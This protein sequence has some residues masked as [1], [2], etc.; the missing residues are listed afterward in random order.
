MIQFIDNTETT[1][2]LPGP[3]L[4]DPAELEQIELETV[5][6]AVP[7]ATVV[8][9]ETDEEADPE[10][11]PQADD[12]LDIEDS[13]RLYLREIARVPLLTAEEEVVLA[14]SIELGVR[15]QGRAVDGRA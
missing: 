2:T 3:R 5:V 15:I 10:P 13:T 11:V 8:R 7:A 1:D 4:V 9:I 14:K 12:V 6:E